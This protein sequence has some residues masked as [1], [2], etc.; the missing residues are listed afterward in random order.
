MTVLSRHSERQSRRAVDAGIF[1][2]ESGGGQ[3]F[4]RCTRYTPCLKEQ[5]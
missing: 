5:Q 1:A 4:A 2:K 3:T